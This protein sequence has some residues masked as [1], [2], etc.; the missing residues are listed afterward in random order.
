MS[1]ADTRS[2]SLLQAQFRALNLSLKGKEP[3]D[4]QGTVSPL[5]TILM[6]HGGLYTL[7]DRDMMT[8][9]LVPLLSGPGT[10]DM[11]QQDIS[12]F[13]NSIGD[14][15]ASFFQHLVPSV[16]YTLDSSLISH[17]TLPGSGLTY[18]ND[19]SGNPPSEDS[20]IPAAFTFVGQFIDHDLTMNG[21]DL[22]NP[23]TGAV[24]DTASPLIDLDSVYG[25]RT[26][27]YNLPTP[28]P[29]QPAL[30]SSLFNEDGTF[31]LHKKAHAGGYFYDLPRDPRT[32]KAYIADAR[33]DENQMVLQVHMLIMRVHN[34]LITT[35]YSGIADLRERMEAAYTETLYNWQSVL[36]DDYLPR[37]LYK[38]SSYDTLAFLRGELAK[39]NFGRFRYKPCLDLTTGKYLASLPHEFAIGFR[40]GH[41]Q[42]K[43]KYEMKQGGP[44]IP[45][46]NN[47]LTADAHGTYADMR[48]SQPMTP[49]H[50]LD[51]QFFAGTLPGNLID[52]KVTSVVF[53]LPESA[54][55]D[56]IKFVGNLAQR[57]LIR[58]SQVGLCGGEDLA[59][60]YNQGLT[61][62]DPEWVTVLTPQQ[63]DPEITSADDTDP[64][65]RLYLRQ[66]YDHLGL[67]VTRSGKAVTEFATPLWYYILKEAEVQGQPKGSL[68][69][70]G[71]RLV[72]EVILGAIG[73]GQYSVLNA[74]GWTS[75]LPTATPGKVTLLDLA[76]Y[77]AE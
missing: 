29:G 13:V 8:G 18:T 40:F 59:N 12:S 19:S 21:V 3:H 41:S 26:L 33:N 14:R 57:N 10:P 75:K 30:P 58:S 6:R 5:L 55:P 48:G 22:F 67:P 42:L 46:F 36:L 51:W 17:L 74:Q 66:K 2:A 56:D 65:Y 60:F 49:D 73:W 39:Q 54:I 44:A 7:L 25:P 23:Q 76:A 64:I 61:S 50:S 15:V 38:D 47:S 69:K 68:G 31:K 63:V 20:P 11:A 72:G 53:D 70:L 27:L 43:P 35:E 9:R 4:A 77:A 1:V 37:I 16:G 24:Q 71:S 62:S 52:G 28:P 45:L 32:H 34:E